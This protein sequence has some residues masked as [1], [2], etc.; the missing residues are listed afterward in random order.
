MTP[1]RAVVRDRIPE[2]VYFRCMPDSKMRHFRR[3]NFSNNKAFKTRERLASAHINLVSNYTTPHHPGVI[4]VATASVT[5]DVGAHFRI[6]LQGL[7]H[8]VFLIMGLRC[9]IAFSL[10]LAKPYPCV[11]AIQHGHYASAH[12]ASSQPK[13]GAWSFR[14]AF[15]TTHNWPPPG[16]FRDLGLC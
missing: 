4:P 11:T 16:E 5:F 1:R 2:L 10:Q 8:R 14:H 6:I 13:T 3:W 12:I 9:T 7:S 15:H